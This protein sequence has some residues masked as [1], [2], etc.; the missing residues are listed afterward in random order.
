MSEEDRVK[1]I[2]DRAARGESIGNQLMYHKAS[3][4]LVPAGSCGDSDKVIRLT[5]QDSHLW[6]SQG[7]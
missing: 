1:E 2:F 4:R 6:A 7:R 3:K 5:N